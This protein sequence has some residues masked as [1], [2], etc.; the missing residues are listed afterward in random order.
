MPTTTQRTGTTQSV[1]PKDRRL[2]SGYRVLHMQVPEPIFN[3]AKAAALL[4]GTPWP[5]FVTGLLAEA[6]TRN[7][8]SGAVQQGEAP[9]ST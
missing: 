6:G 8:P 3:S 9:A 4:Q 1:R 7:L 5:Q 2:A